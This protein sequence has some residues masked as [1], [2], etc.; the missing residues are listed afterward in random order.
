M[1]PWRRASQPSTP[2]EAPAAAK[3]QKGLRVFLRDDKPLES[4]ARRLEQG[5][6][7]AQRPA[8]A[9]GDGAGGGNGNVSLVLMLGLDAEVE[10]RLPGS[11]KVSPQIA[12]AIKAVPGVVSV[13]LI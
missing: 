5:Q 13:E 4:I 8:A 9:R 6:P 12:G 3:S 10:I 11:F 2:S 1:G 7:A